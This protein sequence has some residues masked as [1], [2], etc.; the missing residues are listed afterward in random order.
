LAKVQ[1]TA[2]GTKYFVLITNSQ[3]TVQSNTV[4]LTVLKSATAVKITTQPVALTVKKNTTAKFTVKATGTAPL[5]YQ[6]QKGSANLVNGGQISGATTA[7]LSIAK[8]TSAN[9]GSYR[10]AITNPA[11]KVT[12]A[13]A[14]LKVQ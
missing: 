14:V 10:V 11:G 3:G 2:T 9:A 6:W 13:A 7:S 8:A 4:T 5:L 12:S 1:S